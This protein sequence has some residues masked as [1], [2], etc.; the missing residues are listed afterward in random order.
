MED[1]SFAKRAIPCTNADSAPDEIR[2]PEVSNPFADS[3]SVGDSE[4]EGHYQ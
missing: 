3:L 4:R 2:T 1:L